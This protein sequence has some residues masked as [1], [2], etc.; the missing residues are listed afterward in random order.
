[1]EC[2]EC[3]FGYVPDYPDNVRLHDEYHDKI[4]NGLHAPKIESDK[5]VWQ[6]G[7]LQISVVNFFSP[8]E[9]RKRA[10]EAGRFSQQRYKI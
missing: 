2:P 8:I 5:I 4:V 9:Q 3:G 1:M 7:D 10:E 6:E